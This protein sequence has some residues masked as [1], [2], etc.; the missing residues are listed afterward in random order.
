V[1]LRQAGHS[2]L[3]DLRLHLWCPQHL[4]DL[5]G[6][7][8]RATA[9]ETAHG[10]QQ[11]V[12]AGL[13]RRGCYWPRSAESSEPGQ[14]VCDPVCGVGTSPRGRP[15]RPPRGSSTA[16]SGVVTPGNRPPSRA[17]AHKGRRPCASSCPRTP[18]GPGAA[19]PASRRQITGAHRP[20]GLPPA[21]TR[22]QDGHIIAELTC[23][24]RNERIA[25]WLVCAAS[26]QLR[27]G[28]TAQRTA[29]SGC[30]NHFRTTYSVRVHCPTPQQLAGHITSLIRASG[31]AV[32]D[33]WGGWWRGGS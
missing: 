27:A 12:H 15:P 14:L 29:P 28:G 31:R 7:R 20:D 18:L 6:Q 23:C 4:G 30:A 8:L 1:A 24:M 25:D 32:L 13:G 16:R 3:A 10:R 17:R 33:P 2:E 5:A 26:C 11:D 22:C 19:S 9:G 21:R